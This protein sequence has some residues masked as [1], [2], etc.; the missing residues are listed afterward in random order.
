MNIFLAENAKSR[1]GIS[2][3][4]SQII[5]WK[6]KQLDVNENNVLEKNEYQGLKKIAKTVNFLKSLKFQKSLFHFF[7]LLS[8]NAVDVD[9]VNI[10]I[11]IKISLSV[12][13]SFINVSAKIYRNVSECTSIVVISAQ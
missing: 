10:A 4:D 2:M 7:R 9:S 6:F 5:E 12:G 11:K 1:A 8:L 13:R 3:G